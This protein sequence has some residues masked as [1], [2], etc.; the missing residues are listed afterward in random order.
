[1]KQFDQV[2]P[3]EY[4]NPSYPTQRI[5]QLEEMFSTLSKD[6]EEHFFHLVLIVDGLRL[7]FLEADNFFK[8]KAYK[9]YIRLLERQSDLKKRKPAMGM[10]NIREWEIELRNVEVSI[11]GIQ[12]EKERLL[13]RIKAELDGNESNASP[14]SFTE[15][16]NLRRLKLW[17][18]KSVSKK[19]AMDLQKIA[20]D[21]VTWPF[22]Y[23]SLS[24]YLPMFDLTG[25]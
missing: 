6:P 16:L 1:M 14:Q 23:Q 8:G 25:C 15:Y 22:L 11:D 19:K 12:Q 4:R 24:Q 5:A 3:E 18:G 9:E 2:F 10:A 17:D 7:R 20:T 21:M 13:S